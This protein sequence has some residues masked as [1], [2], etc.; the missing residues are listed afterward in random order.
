M[1]QEPLGNR[2]FR[3]LERM[4]RAIWVAFP[5]YVGFQVWQILTLPDRLAALDPAMKACL[6]NLPMVQT[7]SP[8]G[9]V[10]YWTLFA[11]EISVYALLLVLAHRVLR[12]CAAGHLFFPDLVGALRTI[13]VIITAWPVVDLVLQNVL[14]GTLSALGDLP[15]F[16]PS[17]DLDVTVLGVGLL[18][19]TVAAA[20]AEA[21]RLREDAELTI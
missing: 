19:L 12:R 20:M 3:R 10:F 13:A 15:S 21:V 11:I 18:M 17:L 16:T 7:F 5:L 2:T 1:A 8:S 4:Y 6:E 14:L 9:Q